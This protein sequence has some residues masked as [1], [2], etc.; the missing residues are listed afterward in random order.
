MNQT[1][2]LPSA[3]ASA[4]ALPFPTNRLVRWRELREYLGIS[5]AQMHMLSNA[6]KLPAFFR[7]GRGKFFEPAE[8]TAWLASRRNVA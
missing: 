8:I 1:N 3:N 4:V 5:D 6:G 2:D 7:V